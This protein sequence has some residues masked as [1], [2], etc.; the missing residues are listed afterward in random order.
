M[1]DDSGYFDYFDETEKYFNSLPNTSFEPAKCFFCRNSQKSETTKLFTRTSLVISKCRCGL[2]FNSYQPTDS[3]L[4]KFYTNSDA[5]S[6]WSEIKQ[7]KQEFERQSKKFSEAL[8]YIF[9]RPKLVES[10]LDYGCGNGF[11]LSLIAASHP[12]TELTGIDLSQV[13]LD[14]I[15]NPAIE[16]ICGKDIPDKKFDV[17][18]CFGLLEHMKH[19]DHFLKA[20]RE[21]LLPGGLVAA[22]V[23]NVESE[24]VERLGAQAATFCPQHLWYFSENTLARLFT[25][26]GFKPA[27]LYSIEEERVPIAKKIS[28]LHPYNP[29]PEWCYAHNLFRPE[30][31]N[32]LKNM[33][34][35]KLV[36]IGK[37]T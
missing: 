11:L 37:K 2:V 4:E 24:V 31:K 8:I 3:A 12:E 14:K 33:K 5:M 27:Y 17:I 18:T 36:M 6:K 35:Y 9:N 10:L 29:A 21:H 20:A 28:L 30:F 23:P 22:C 26:S 13:A 16:K 15:T 32:I 19:P 1:A 25:E 7:T 34:G